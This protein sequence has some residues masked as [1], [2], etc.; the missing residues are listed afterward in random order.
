MRFVFT[1][2]L[3]CLLLGSQM[4]ALHKAYN[5]G[6]QLYIGNTITS[7][8]PMSINPDL[9]SAINKAHEFVSKLTLTEK[10]GM[11]T[12]AA[13]TGGCTGNI[14]PIERIGFPGLCVSDG[15]AAVNPADLVSIFPAGVTTAA[16]WDRDLIYKRA[17][18]LGSEFKG[19]GT[20]IALAPVGA[21]LGRHPLGGTNWEGF[22]PDPYLSGASMALTIKGMQ[23]AGVQT[24]SKHFIGSEQETQRH[25]I[26]SNIDDRTLHELYLWP[27]A[28]AVKAGTASILCSYNRLNQT[29]SCENPELLNRILKKELGFQGYVMSDFFAT[30]SGVKSIHAGLDLN[31]PGVINAGSTKTYFGDNVIKAV[32][33]GSV[34]L[35][36]VDDMV[37]RIMTPYFLLG[38]NQGYPTT[39]KSVGCLQSCGT[40]FT[41]GCGNNQSCNIP[42]RDVRGDHASIIRELGAAGT[43]LLKNTNSALP[44]RAPKNIG[45]FGNDAA[46]LA[47]G[48]AFVQPL[49][50]E[51]FDIGTLD[52]GGGPGSGRHSYIVSPLEA[53][54]ARARKTAARVQYITNNAILASNDFHGI[55]PVPDVCLVFLK[56]YGAE[57][58]D[59][60][61]FELSW[62]ST[63]VVINVASHCPNTVVVTHSGGVNTM[64]WATNPNVTAILAAHYPGQETGNSIVDILWGDVN[65]SAK[66]PYTIP[67]KESDYHIPI[68]NSTSPGGDW[69]S[70]FTEGLFIDYRHFDE[71]DIT[72]LFE[73]GYGLSYTI[74]DITSPVSI[75]T[76]SKSITALP[77]PSRTVE[78]G[79]N[80][81]LWASLLSAETTV[82]NT[83]PV[84]GSAVVQL[85]ISFPRDT[86]PES[87]PVKVLRGFEKV[88]LG[89]GEKKSVA[90][91]LTRRDV[92]FW[93]TVA[94]EWRLP[95]GEFEISIGFSSR[96]LRISKTATFL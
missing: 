70:D 30:N 35:A 45:V 2:G 10:A 14:A 6:F 25:E 22:G 8:K 11:V 49:P 44:L 37:R 52:I 76:L 33:N 96:D 93:D 78:P 80:P 89:V 41:P 95:E 53:I 77:D 90:F 21:A 84:V 46:D 20:N 67:V 65:P 74:F 63:A 1:L 86:V 19:K 18:A 29:H 91:D 17:F 12:G 54:K 83:G 75:T 24:A 32:N 40:S 88:R 36:R 85:Y 4:L 71:N 59:R 3:G 81:D 38:Q 58:Q 31:V 82:S 51:G 47:D 28:E 15:P 72:P 55:Y 27:F 48:L 16:S 69:Q 26:S 79:G 66:L 92:S 57:E 62:N 23:T 7:T 50:E 13:T 61:S 68:V 42:A 56:T 94:Q 9:E 64:P 60:T 34:S 39:D 73:F 5:S 43:V 87:T